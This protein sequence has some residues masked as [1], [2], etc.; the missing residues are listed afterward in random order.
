M[1]NKK[2][3][4]PVIL[5]VILLCGIVFTVVYKKTSSTSPNDQHVVETLAPKETKE[6][7]TKVVEEDRGSLKDFEINEEVREKTLDELGGGIVVAID[8]MEESNKDNSISSS[9]DNQ[10]LSTESSNEN[11]GESNITSE[12]L[13]NEEVESIRNQ[14]LD[15]SITIQK[16][17]ESYD[18]LFTPEER[19]SIAAETVGD[20]SMYY[21]PE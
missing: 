21:L 6:I 5:G 3:M 15:W 17:D 8:N 2:V 9:K 1:E 19:E 7:E 20:I 10:E 16:E 4:I 11:I 18:D 13:S 12:T 14:Y